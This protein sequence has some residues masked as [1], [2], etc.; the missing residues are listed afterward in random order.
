MLLDALSALEMLLHLRQTV[1]TEHILWDTI[2]TVA[3]QPIVRATISKQ[4]TGGESGSKSG[5]GEGGRSP[6]EE[7]G[8]GGLH[9]REAP[10]ERRAGGEGR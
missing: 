7:V 6:G 9:A 5:R 1:R 4:P 3:Q 8:S 10:T 2:S